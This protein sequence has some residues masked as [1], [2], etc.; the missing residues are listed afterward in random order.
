MLS[1]MILLGSLRAEE[2]ETRNVS[3]G[4]FIRTSRSSNTENE[5]G[6]GAVVPLACQ[7]KPQPSGIERE[8]RAV[9]VGATTEVALEAL[10]KVG[11]ICEVKI[12]SNGCGGLIREEKLTCGMLNP[13]ALCV[14]DEGRARGFLKKTSQVIERHAHEW[15]QR[16]E[17]H[18]A[19]EIDAAFDR[20]HSV[21]DL[22]T[23]GDAVAAAPIETILLT[24]ME[25]DLQ[26]GEPGQGF[27][28]L[29]LL[30]LILEDAE[31]C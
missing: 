9:L 11:G 2:L 5:C 7:L 18:G 3:Y 23:E 13:A 4:G 27:I 29:L 17:T 21:H 14:V 26:H 6:A 20:T 1:S 10:G 24:D 16:G 15:L 12:L 25:E 22:R 30:E 19:T 28:D 8:V 31:V